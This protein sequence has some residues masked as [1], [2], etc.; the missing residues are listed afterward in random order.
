L[1]QIVAVVDADLQRD[2]DRLLKTHMLRNHL[3]AGED[4]MLR[5]H[6]GVG[7]YL[8]SRW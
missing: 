7:G 8:S 2:I 1:K 3:E 4:K 5:L 6:S